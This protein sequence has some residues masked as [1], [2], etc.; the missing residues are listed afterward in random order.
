METVLSF[1]I[2]GTY[3]RYAVVQKDIIIEMK[4]EYSPSF[5]RYMAKQCEREF[6]RSPII[7]DT[8]DELVIQKF[9]SAI[10]NCD[11]F[12]LKVLD[13]AV[14]KLVYLIQTISPIF[15]IDRYVLVGGVA[16]ALGEK[17]LQSINRQLKARG[18]FGWNKEE[19]N[20]LVKLGIPNDDFGLIGAAQYGLFSIK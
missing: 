8:K 9:S 16:F 14:A 20:G 11:T 7:L 3:L 12:A 2:G 17:L 18:I 6:N 10:H 15:G 13:F 5:I 19:L 4:K 1:D